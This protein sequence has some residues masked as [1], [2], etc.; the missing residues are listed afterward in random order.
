MGITVLQINIRN[1]D[2]NK[3]LLQVELPN[4][5]PDIILVNE[6][7]KTKN[8]NVKLTGYR[9]IFK[10]LDINS[11]VAILIKYDFQFYEIPVV[12]NNTIAIKLMTNMGPILISTSYVPPR[13]KT[14]PIIAYNKL[15]NY[16]LPLILIGDLNA[17][18]AFLHNTSSSNP[19]GD[20]KGKQLFNL[21]N[22]RNLKFIGPFFD[23]YIQNNR[24][25]KPDVVLINKKMNLF[26][27]NIIQGSHVGSDHVPVIIKLSLQP[28]KFFKQPTI[29]LKN[30]DI[31]KY[32]NTLKEVKF[33]KLNNRPI[34][35]IDKLTSKLM[36]NIHEATKSSCT[37][38]KIYCIKSYN[39]TCRIKLKMRQ[40]QAAY[41]S[42]LQF[43]FPN[44]EKTQ[45]IKDELLELILNEKQILWETL[46]QIAQDCFKNPSKFWRRVKPLLGNSLHICRPLNQSFCIAHRQPLHMEFT[47]VLSILINS[48]KT[49]V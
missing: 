15:L 30:M 28:F 10:S 4:T 13:V 2:K 32:K 22:C 24:R 8:N 42:Y 7:G 23:T 16:N 33:D 39:P 20:L 19:Y 49:I 40:F 47:H 25:G 11:G 27:H 34:E 9:S 43:G 31:D 21:S 3:Y 18:H 46:I 5:N 48:Y 29:N 45:Q 1:W 6:T 12:D 26:H 36:E 35:E 38:N 41:N 14:L 37:L 17:H 44:L